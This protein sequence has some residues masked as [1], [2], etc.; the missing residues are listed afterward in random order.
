M[1]D[2]PKLTADQLRRMWD[3]LPGP[4]PGGDDG[5]DD[6]DESGDEPEAREPEGSK[7][8]GHGDEPGGC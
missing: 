3:E 4:E 2:D 8:A 6:P 5:P 1:A 7:Q